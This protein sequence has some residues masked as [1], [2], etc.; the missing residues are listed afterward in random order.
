MGMSERAAIERKNRLLA[1]GRT[2]FMRARKLAAAG[3][4][5]RA[6]KLRLRI[7][8]KLQSIRPPGQTGIFVA[9][10]PEIQELLR[11]WGEQG[12]PI[13]EAGLRPFPPFMEKV[14]RAVLANEG[15]P[16]NPAATLIP[17]L[18]VCCSREHRLLNL[19]GMCCDTRSRERISIMRAAI[20]HGDYSRDMQEMLDGGWTGTEADYQKVLPN[21]LL[22]FFH[23][24]NFIVSQI[25][26]DLGL[27]TWRWEANRSLCPSC[28]ARGLSI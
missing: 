16:V 11:P 27:F 2:L 12:G 28:K 22:G 24:L 13:T 1:N 19:L 4:L 7:D 10:H 26:P 3:D 6:E 5:K 18:Q 20:V 25:D 9:D 14:L 23:K 17:M 21:R 8:R 15:V